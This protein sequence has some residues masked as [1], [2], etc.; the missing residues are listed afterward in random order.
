M[1]GTAVSCSNSAYSAPARKRRAGG[2]DMIKQAD[3]ATNK[4]NV[5]VVKDCPEGQFCLKENQSCLNTS[6]GLRPP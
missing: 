5:N 3:L 6:R 4:L 2:D 1:T